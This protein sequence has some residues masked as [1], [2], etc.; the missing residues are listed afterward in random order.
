[1]PDDILEREKTA[2][3]TKVN[4]I[5]RIYGR[6]TVVAEA[7]VR[8]KRDFLWVCRCECG[9]S[10]VV[11]GQLLQLG[12]TRS[13]GCYVKDKMRA[14][15]TTHGMTNTSEYH[16]W[17]KLKRRCYNKN[18]KQYRNY[19]A[20]GITVCERWRTSFDAFLADMGLRPSHDHSIDRIDNNGRY[21]PGNCRWATR[22]EQAANTR[23]T[24]LVVID[25]VSLPIC[26][27][28]RKLGV[29]PRTIRRRLK[30]GLVRLAEKQP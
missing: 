20:R 10:V 6:L 29:A 19:G 21:E 14:L 27:A 4:R 26:V 30:K 12:R 2:G 22:V 16:T 9:A 17:D 28:A 7:S 25:G 1:M 23:H 15:K 24:R 3:T 11:P 18:D 13:C 5:G 8:R